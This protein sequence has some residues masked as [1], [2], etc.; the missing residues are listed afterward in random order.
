[1]AADMQ[2]VNIEEEYTRLQEHLRIQ[3]ELE[4]LF[5]DTEYETVIPKI[6][7]ILEG[8]SNRKGIYLDHLKC[9]GRKDGTA[10]YNHVKCMIG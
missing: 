5:C 7:N 8:K 9:F 2:E 10:I 1:M 3:K 4:E 6:Q